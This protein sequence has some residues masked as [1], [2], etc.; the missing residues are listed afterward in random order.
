MSQALQPD[1]GTQRLARHDPNSVVPHGGVPVAVS[2]IDRACTG[3]YGSSHARFMG[4]ARNSVY[5]QSSA[6]RP[7]ESGS[8][9][10]SGSAKSKPASSACVEETQDL[11]RAALRQ[12]SSCGSS[13]AVHGSLPPKQAPRE[14]G[15]ACSSWPVCRGLFVVACLLWPIRHARKVEQP[16]ASC[17][18][19]VRARR[20]RLNS[21]L[22]GQDAGE[23]RRLRDAVRAEEEFLQPHRTSVV[24]DRAHA[25][26]G[27]EPTLHER[28]GLV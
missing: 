16:A 25:A 19:P 7:P 28:A 26:E 20:V 17:H 18:G 11:Q 1:S 14:V 4:A 23:W 3:V 6:S 10:R 8:L 22:R 2:G 5:S 9:S 24:R 12:P 21:R 27:L 15:G 13:R